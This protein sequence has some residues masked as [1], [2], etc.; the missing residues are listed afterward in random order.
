MSQHLFG[1][2]LMGKLQHFMSV[3]EVLKQHV[4]KLGK[5]EEYVEHAHQ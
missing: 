4:S 2:K 3:Y 5:G 1:L